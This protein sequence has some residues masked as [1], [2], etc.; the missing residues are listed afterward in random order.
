MK[1]K[2]PIRETG[3]ATAG[4]MVARQFPRNTNTTRITNMTAWNR[5]TTTSLIEIRM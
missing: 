3:M 1:A 2:V 5:V 4:T